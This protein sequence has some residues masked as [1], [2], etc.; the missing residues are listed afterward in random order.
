MCVC[1][2]CDTPLVIIVSFRTLIKLLPL[3]PVSFTPFFLGGGG[4]RK[5]FLIQL[6]YKN[7]SILFLFSAADSYWYSLR[8]RATEVYGYYAD[9]RSSL[10]YKAIF[11]QW[12]TWK[13]IK[14]SGHCLNLQ[15][16]HLILQPYYFFYVFFFVFFSQTPFN[17]SWLKLRHTGF[18]HCRNR[19]KKKKKASP[20][21]VRTHPSISLYSPQNVM[22]F[23]RS[24]APGLFCLFMTE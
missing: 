6:N 23:C 8:C 18:E 24:E 5:S 2:L 16:F 10:T 3:L 14:P 20:C 19:R 1:V 11:P 4:Q 9:A 7:H 21:G 17:L 13:N 22:F 12:N 15:D